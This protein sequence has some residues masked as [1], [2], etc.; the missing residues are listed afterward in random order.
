MWLRCAAALAVTGLMTL[1]SKADDTYAEILI[2]AAAMT[3]IAPAAATITME[4]WRNR[5]Y[6][7]PEPPRFGDMVLKETLAAEGEE[8]T[9]LSYEEAVKAA[10]G[11]EK[12][13]AS[14]I[15]NWQPGTSRTRASDLA[16]GSRRSTE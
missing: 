16:R 10:P 11:L 15:W 7:E 5:G 3:A 14:A 2:M 12:A 1:S 8:A 9:A 4:A 6:V 13:T